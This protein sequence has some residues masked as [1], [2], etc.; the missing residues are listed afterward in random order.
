MSRDGLA[1]I[2]VPA[3]MRENR[4]FRKPLPQRRSP[5][6]RTFV[7]GPRWH[8]RELGFLRLDSPLS[9]DEFSVSKPCPHHMVGRKSL[10]GF[11]FLP[12]TPVEHK[13][14]P[15][16]ASSVTPEL[17]FLAFRKLDRDH[18]VSLVSPWFLFIL[19]L[20]AAGRSERLNQIGNAGKA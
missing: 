2:F 9:Q 5:C 12:S 14:R 10:G 17:L 6:A 13:Y 8:P 19:A 15:T 20:K 11:Q 4:F 3:K 16:E 7:P 1:G 18:V